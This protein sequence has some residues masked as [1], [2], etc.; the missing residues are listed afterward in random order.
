MTAAARS[1]LNL[2][3]TGKGNGV[4]GIELGAEDHLAKPFELRELLAQVRSPVSCR[5]FVSYARPASAFGAA[6][7]FSCCISPK[8]TFEP[9]SS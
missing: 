7:S 1:L 3:F 8:G 2:P 5:L 9:V 4:V 6:V